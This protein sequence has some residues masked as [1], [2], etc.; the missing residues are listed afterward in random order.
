MNGSKVQLVKLGRV[1][2]DPDCLAGSETLAFSRHLDH[3]EE[4]SQ[5]EA[6]WEQIFLSRHPASRE[7]QALKSI[8]DGGYTV[9]LLRYVTHG[10]PKRLFPP[11][12]LQKQL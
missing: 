11:V 12:G 10:D 8:W 5:S 6:E 4:S 3:M 1:Y 2:L 7:R 9:C